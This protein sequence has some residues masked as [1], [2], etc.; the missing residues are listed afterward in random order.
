MAELHAGLRSSLEA[1]EAL[2]AANPSLDYDRMMH[3]HPLLGT[4]NVPHLL[5]SMGLHEER[6]QA[7]MSD[8]L[9]NSQF[10]RA[11]RD[12]ED[13]RLSPALGDPAQAQRAC[14]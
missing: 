10:P 13:S 8:L 2:L 7:H 1:L 6:H 9:T 14:T 4:Q 3:Q 5:Y 12:V 11:G